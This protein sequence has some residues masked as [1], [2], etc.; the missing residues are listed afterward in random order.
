MG[1]LLIFANKKIPI[2][3]FEKL[4]THFEKKEKLG[5]TFIYE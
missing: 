4:R 1:H 5:R 2:G 3:F